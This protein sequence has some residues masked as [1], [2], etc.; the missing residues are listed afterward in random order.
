MSYF[1]YL[2]DKEFLKQLDEER[3]REIYIRIEVL[4]FTTEQTIANIEGKSTGGS[5]NLNGTSNMRRSGSLSMVVD[6]NGID[7]GGESQDY[8]AIT[9]VQNLISMNK[10]I[11]VF[12]GVRNTIG[13]PWSQYDIIWF[14]QGVYVI[15]SGNAARNGGGIN[16][17]LT[18][19]DKCA[20]LNGDMGGTIPAATIFSES[21]LYNSAGTVRTV[22]PVLIK[23]M[24]KRIVVEFGGEKPENVIIEDIPESIVKVIK[25]TGKDPLYLITTDGHKQYTLEQPTENSNLEYKTFVYGQDVGYMN[26][27]FVYPGRLECNAGESAASV[28]DKLKNT[29]GNFEWFYDVHGRFHFQEIKNY[30][31]TS[32]STEILNLSES[33][34]LMTMNPT[35]SSYTFDNHNIITSISNAPQYA[36]IKNDFVVWGTRKTSTGVQKPIRYHLAFEDKP[37]PRSKPMDALV[38]DDY[39]G[40]QS[41]IKLD[42]SNFNDKPN[43]IYKDVPTGEVEITY[44]QDET[45]KTINETVIKTTELQK[46]FS[47]SEFTYAY[48][49]DIGELPY[50]SEAYIGEYEGDVSESSNTEVS[51]TVTSLTL[52][53]PKENYSIQEEPIIISSEI[54][55]VGNPTYDRSNVTD[56]S[57][58]IKNLFTFGSSINHPEREE[59]VSIQDGSLEWC[60]EDDYSSK[61]SSSYEYLFEYLNDTEP[62]PI[63]YIGNRNLPFES[64]PILGIVLNGQSNEYTGWYWNTSGGFIGC[65]LSNFNDLHS[66]FYLDL[67]LS[68]FYPE[69]NYPV[70]ID[71]YTNLVF[72]D[73]FSIQNY[74]YFIDRESENALDYEALETENNLTVLRIYPNNSQR[75]FLKIEIV[76]ANSI[77]NSG[78]LSQDSDSTLRFNGIIASNC[79][80]YTATGIKKYQNQVKTETTLLT[81]TE[82]LYTEPKIVKK[83]DIM[84]TIEVP[85][86]TKDSPKVYYLAKNTIWAWDDELKDFREFPNYKY[87]KLLPGDWRTEL[88]FQGLEA[89]DK[90]FSRN[91]Y[92]AELNAEW[93]KICN[94]LDSYDEETEI[95]TSAYWPDQKADLYEYWLDFIEASDFSINNIGRRVKVITD[96][97]SNCLFPVEVPNYIIVEADG[98]VTNERELAEKKR[99]EVIQVS[100]S[101]FK[102]L[103]LG[104]SQN[105]AFDKIKELLNTHTQYN[106]SVTLSVI[107]IYYLEPNTRITINDPQMGIQGDYLIK[108]ISL[109][110]TA[111]GT[112]NISCTKALSKTI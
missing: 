36:N 35:M 15:K 85:N 55:D 104:G 46:E 105:A 21:E 33:D 7:I 8:Y 95:Y 74:L 49:E 4:D 67:N 88:Y 24:A 76:D 37:T 32:L 52:T 51:E 23:D 94:V 93:P 101:I 44:S 18:I 82:Y 20:L 14:P 107:P 45:C 68:A 77:L 75:N 78:Y 30:L 57:E 66:Y 47:V 69:T 17:S 112:S 25:W 79:M 108:S 56:Q 34:Y 1:P 106:E 89:S 80:R 81:T 13:D 109:P 99:Q 59:G 27:P 12:S 102:N 84:E 58:L 16:L 96:N 42:E 40:L 98:D 73:N 91:Y 10:K 26:E 22:E 100:P 62:F 31:N 2:E 28:L 97:N 90:T 65:N 50:E 60:N 53:E 71:I 41:V 86:L 11:R 19:N 83:E 92:A 5:I 110:L 9:D 54:E 29:L 63:F 70:Y 6:P 38:Y 3:Y 111:S 87:C 48:D 72:V 103:S 43:L 39:R 64:S 61:M